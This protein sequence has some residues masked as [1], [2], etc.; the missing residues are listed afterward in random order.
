MITDI[1]QITLDVSDLESYEIMGVFEGNVYI[2]SEQIDYEDESE[3]PEEHIILIIPI[4]EYVRAWHNYLL[5]KQNICKICNSFYRGH[6]GDFRVEKG[7]NLKEK[8][9]IAIWNEEKED[10]EFVEVETF[11]IDKF[12][13]KPFDMEGGGMATIRFYPPKFS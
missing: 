6:Y 12:E 13:D 4:E 1:S 2:D 11:K 7:E 10:I 5:A 3:K 8:N 9:P